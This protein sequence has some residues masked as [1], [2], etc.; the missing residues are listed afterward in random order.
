MQQDDFEYSEACRGDSSDRAHH[1][2]QVNFPVLASSSSRRNV[3]S[4]QEKPT[5]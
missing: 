2:V 4:A 1:D 5:I 3:G